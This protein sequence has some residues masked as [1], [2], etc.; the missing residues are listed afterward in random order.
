[1][2]AIMYRSGIPILK[3][4]EVCGRLVRNRSMKEEVELIN[5]RIS[6]G[7]NLSAAMGHSGIFPSIAVRMIAIG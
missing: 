1:M 4:L 3:A 6:T 7:K 2:L 5:A